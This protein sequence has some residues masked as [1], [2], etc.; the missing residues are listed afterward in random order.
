[1]GGSH[2]IHA[3]NIVQCTY[4]H[5]MLRQYQR[6]YNQMTT[7][8]LALSYQML[9]VCLSFLFHHAH[10]HAHTEPHSIIHEGWCVKESG[11][12]LFG[13]TN[14]RRRWF[15]LVQTKRDILLQY[16][17]SDTCRMMFVHLHYMHFHE[18]SEVDSL[19]VCSL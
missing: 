2:Y 9:C 13:K 15:R 18:Y 1:M 7:N 14:W 11:T 10:T 3:Q 19:P 17:R 4:T 12:A 6:Y 16:Y 8:Y 5:T